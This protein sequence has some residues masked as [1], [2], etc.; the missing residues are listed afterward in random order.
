[1][2]CFRL[3]GTV[4]FWR[5]SC[6]P[7]SKSVHTG[8]SCATTQ[9]QDRVKSGTKHEM[10]SRQKGA[11]MKSFLESYSLVMLPLQLKHTF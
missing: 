6:P 10:P 2:Q 9:G 8:L 7:P 3:K 11:E 5:G 1:M 4:R